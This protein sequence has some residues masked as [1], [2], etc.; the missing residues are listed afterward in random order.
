MHRRV[1]TGLSANFGF[2]LE[3][4]G[5]FL[6]IHGLYRFL[7]N[8]RLEMLVVRTSTRFFLGIDIKLQVAY[9]QSM[10]VGVGCQP[11]A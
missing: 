2:F 1:I 10:L 11:N 7:K 6:W 3:L 8:L 4:M 9:F 5:I